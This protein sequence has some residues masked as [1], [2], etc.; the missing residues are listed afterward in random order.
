MRVSKPLKVACLYTVF[1]AA[2]IGRIASLSLSYV[3]L[4][5]HRWKYCRTTRT[6]FGKRLVSRCLC[7]LLALNHASQ[8]SR[9]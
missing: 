8:F 6:D 3:P 7:S 9:D 5:D 2:S 4:G 1:L